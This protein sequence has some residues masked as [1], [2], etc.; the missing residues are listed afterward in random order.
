MGASVLGLVKGS[1]Q[2]NTSYV[3]SITA[4]TKAGSGPQSRVIRVT[5][6]KT[7][8]IIMFSIFL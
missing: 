5:L 2:P 3:I 6:G 7:A 8:G 4:T 1:L